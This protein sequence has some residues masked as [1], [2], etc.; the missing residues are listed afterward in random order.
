MNNYRIKKVTRGNGCEYYYPQKRFI[1]FW[2]N[3]KV[4]PL[5]NQSWAN[6]VIIDDYNK[7]IKDIVEFI[8]PNF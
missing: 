4:D 8:E 6:D 7:S 3:L 1:C 2:L 5:M